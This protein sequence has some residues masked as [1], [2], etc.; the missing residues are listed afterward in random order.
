MAFKVSAVCSTSNFESR[1]RESPSYLT[2]YSRMKSSSGFELVALMAS[3][4]S[5][6]RLLL[7]NMVAVPI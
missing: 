6:P 3:S 2:K 1:K 4:T 5:L 7:F